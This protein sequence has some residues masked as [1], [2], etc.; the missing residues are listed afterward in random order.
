MVGPP[1]PTDLARET[2]TEQFV[3]RFVGGSPLQ[4]SSSSSIQ[5][6]GVGSVSLCRR[7]DGGDMMRA[8]G[9]VVL[10][11]PSIIDAAAH[12]DP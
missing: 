8:G 6:P 5:H 3:G 4:R 12:L 2:R 1:P 10:L 9:T 7:G 11:L